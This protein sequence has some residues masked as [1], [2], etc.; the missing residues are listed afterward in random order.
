M[1]P[2]TGSLADLHL[3]LDSGSN[4]NVAAESAPS[5]VTSTST[6]TNPEQSTPVVSISQAAYTIAFVE[7]GE[8]AAG[9]NME[10]NL[11]IRA[12]EGQDDP[13]AMSMPVAEQPPFE[14]A[15]GGDVS[16]ESAAS[17][18]NTNSGTSPSK[19]GERERV[20]KGESAED[21]EKGQ[22][23]GEQSP[24]VDKDGDGG[25]TGGESGDAGDS[26]TDGDRDASGDKA[27]SGSANSSA[28]ASKTEVC[29]ES[30]ENNVGKSED[31]ATKA[32]SEAENKEVSGKGEKGGNGNGSDTGSSDG[33]RGSWDMLSDA[34]HD[35]N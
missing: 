25:A 21:T 20:T 17:D 8:M 2:L 5:V 1:M 33:N 14:I 9:K 4:S 24:A 31:E 11:H 12:E 34:D 7:S 15:A 30:G 13:E 29:D 23:S 3:D 32:P 16:A 35:S 6:I 18:T 28:S 19:E 26:V 27:K 22:N 10:D